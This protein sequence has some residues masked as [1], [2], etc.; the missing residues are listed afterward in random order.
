MAEFPTSIP[1]FTDLDPNTSL[2]AN[3]HA[4]RHNKVHAE[5]EAIAAKVG[6]D[7]STDPTTHTKKIADLRT[8]HDA[9]QTQ[10]DDL[11]AAVPTTSE[12]NAAIAAAISAAK[13]A[14]YPIGSYYVNETDGTNPATLL[15]FGTWTAV[16]NRMIIGKGSGT[17]AT[18]GATGGEENHTLTASEQADMEVRSTAQGQTMGMSF[19]T[20]S[21]TPG[22]TF[23]ASLDATNVNSYT[24]PMIADGGGQPHNNMPPY[25]V[26]HIWKRTA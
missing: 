13:S 21:N 17:F 6:E 26:A 22:V 19:G 24:G 7:G 23:R 20:N 12:M 8:D 11:D 18:A 16:Q 3:N 9:L 14:L 2:A 10:V 4:N 15:G 5:V 25:I 1:S